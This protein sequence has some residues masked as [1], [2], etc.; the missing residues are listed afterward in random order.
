ML[1]VKQFDLANGDG[2]EKSMKKILL[3]M[4]GLMALGA[5]APALAA[6]LPARTFTKAPAVVPSPVYDWSGF[7][8]GLNGGGGSA[9]SCWDLLNVQGTPGAPETEGCH[10]AT[11][12]TVGGQIGYRWQAT[13]WV[14]GVEAQGNWANF[15]GN[16]VDQASVGGVFGDRSKVDAF[17]LFTG[18]V[19]YGFNN[20]LL[21]A[22]GGA[23]VAGD[24]YSTFFNV[25]NL[26]GIPVPAGQDFASASVT[27]WGGTVGAGVEFGFAPHWSVALE[28]DHLF[29]GSRNI[30]LNFLPAFGGG[31]STINHISQDVDIGTVRVNYGFGGPAVAKF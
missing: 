1:S 7:Y 19:G 17:G 9:H 21:Y 27:R 22:K 15:R 16:N 11:G 26:G 23:A 10:N 24:K 2:M 20:V 30:Q 5:A 8:L 14:F 18:Q 29:M 25:A 6:D 13:N 3:G 4:A 31:L 28:Y 12:G